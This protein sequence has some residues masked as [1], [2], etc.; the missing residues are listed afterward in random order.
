MDRATPVYNGK[1]ILGVALGLN[2]YTIPRVPP[3]LG[4]LKVDNMQPSFWWENFFP[5]SRNAGQL[6]QIDVN[7]FF[8]LIVFLRHHLFHQRNTECKRS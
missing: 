5:P 7:M 2:F 8:I 3:W 1:N 4:L 6:L